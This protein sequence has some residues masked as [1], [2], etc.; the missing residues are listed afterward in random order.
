MGT[1]LVSEWINVYISKDGLGCFMDH[2]LHKKH[3][4][5]PIL[6]ESE[7]SEELLIMVNYFKKSKYLL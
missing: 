3:N 6:L 1:C 2:I 7:N 4:Y 5:A